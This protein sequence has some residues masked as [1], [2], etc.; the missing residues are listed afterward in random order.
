MLLVCYNLLKSQN[1]PIN[2]QKRKMV[3]YNDTSDVT[4]KAA[5]V[6]QKTE[7]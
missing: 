2:K 4:K 5:K 3:C 1:I 7:Q 6:A